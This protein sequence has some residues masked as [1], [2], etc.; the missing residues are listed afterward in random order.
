M[1]TADIFKR[2]SR[3]IFIDEIGVPGQR[4]INDAKVLVV[5]SGGLGSPVLRY[6]CAAAVGTLDVVDVDDVEIDT[7][8]RQCIH[9]E[10][11]IGQCKLACAAAFVEALNCQ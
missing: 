8:N 1:E 2:Y 5:A 9:R 3:Q 7:L 4:K 11:T 6:L 10:V